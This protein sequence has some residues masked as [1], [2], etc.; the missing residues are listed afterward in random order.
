MTQKLLRD[1][2]G[3]YRKGTPTPNP[4]GRPRKV[5]LPRHNMPEANRRAVFEVAQMEVA[6]REGGKVV[7]TTTAYMAMLRALVKDAIENGNHVAARTFIKEVK[8]AAATERETSSLTMMLYRENRM[9]KR[10]LERYDK[11]LPRP[12]NGGV[13]ILQPDGT[14]LTPAWDKAMKE[15]IER[16]HQERDEYYEDEAPGLR[17]IIDSALGPA[18]DEAEREWDESPVPDPLDEPS[19]PPEAG[20]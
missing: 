7:G 9:L 14:V 1:A 18:L 12:Q 19:L 15:G 10:D 5:P 2:N 3:R 20:G 6:L 11:I 8:E 17:A 16:P 4:K 13:R